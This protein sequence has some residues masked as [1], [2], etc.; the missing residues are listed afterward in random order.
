MARTVLHQ[1]GVAVE[2]Q[3]FQSRDCIFLENYNLNERALSFVRISSFHICSK[4]SLSLSKN[5]KKIFVGLHLS[6]MSVECC[7]Y[8]I[9][10]KKHKAFI[11]FAL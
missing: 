3:V 9:Y 1:R 6:D 2:V 4:K 10:P 11:Y 7:K 8:M 5:V